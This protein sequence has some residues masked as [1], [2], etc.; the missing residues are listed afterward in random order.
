MVAI[1]GS[2]HDPLVGDAGWS[3]ADYSEVVERL[4]TAALLADANEARTP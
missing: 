3:A 4:L 2:L 1:S